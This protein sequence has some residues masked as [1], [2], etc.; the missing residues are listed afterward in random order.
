M[1]LAISLAAAAGCD[2]RATS[3]AAAAAAPIVVAHPGQIS[4]CVRFA[5]QAP[6]VVMLPVAADPVCAKAHPNGIPDESVVVADDGSMA[7][8]FVYL[9]DAPKSDGAGRAPALLDQVGCQYVPHAVAVQTNQALRVRS[10]DPVLH[11]VHIQAKENPALNLAEVRP[12]EQTVTFSLPEFMRTRCDVHPWMNAIIGVF[13][14]AYFAVTGPDGKFTIGNIPAGTYTLVA[15][16]ERLG[17]QRQKVTIA[18]DQ[19]LHEDLQYRP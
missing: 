3:P 12:G 4:G 18:A 10:S 17:E 13:D 14:S 2:D 9:A 19:T 1:L 6:K 15:W 7:N 16:H 8:V 11:N 5:G